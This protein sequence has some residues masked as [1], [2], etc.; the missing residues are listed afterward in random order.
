MRQDAAIIL[1]ERRLLKSS[2]HRGISL[3]GYNIPAKV[4]VEALSTLAG[5]WSSKF[6][7]K[8]L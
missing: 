2:S 7:K 4:D 1:Q 6:Q 5:S 3:R 8:S